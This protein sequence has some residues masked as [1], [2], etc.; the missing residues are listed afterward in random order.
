VQLKRARLMLRRV[1]KKNETDSAESE[2]FQA[3]D[4]K[5]LEEIPKTVL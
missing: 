4:A 1:L 3:Q 5:T 2:G